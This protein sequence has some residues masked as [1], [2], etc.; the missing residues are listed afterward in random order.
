MRLRDCLFRSLLRRLPSCIDW[1]I[2]QAEQK[3]VLY[4][5]CHLSRGYLAVILLL[6]IL[7]ELMLW[8][9]VQN[10]P[11][12][13]SNVQFCR[14]WMGLLG[15]CI[16]VFTNFAFVRGASVERLRTILEPLREEA[17][18]NGS[19]VASVG[20]RIGRRYLWYIM[21]YLFFVLTSILVFFLEAVRQWGFSGLS[22]E[23]VL[24]LGPLLLTLGAF[25]AV[26]PFMLR[27]QGAGAR[28]LP[29]LGSVT[30]C[31]A[32][33]IASA[34]PL[35][36]VIVDPQLSRSD[37][38]KLLA[39]RSYVHGDWNGP[40]LLLSDGRVA[41]KADVHD[42]YQGIRIMGWALISGSVLF[43]CVGMMFAINSFH[44]TTNVLLYLQQMKR[45]PDF[46]S[47]RETIDPRHFMAPF[48]I[49]W[50]CVWFSL[51]CCL[52]VASA[53]VVRSAL[54]LVASVGCNSSQPRLN[55]IDLSV[56][57]SAMAFDIAP[58]RAWLVWGM[59]TV[60]GCYVLLF[61][62]IM[63]ASIGSFV[64]QEWAARQRLVRATKELEQ[65][66]VIVSLAE[67]L[68]RY[69]PSTQLPDIISI[70]G[71]RIFAHARL[72]GFLRRRAVIEVSSCCKEVLTSEE[73]YALL[74]HELAHHALGHSRRDMTLRFLG[75]LTLVG[76]G[77]VRILEDSFGYEL[78]ADKF[79]VETLGGDPG[80]MIRCLNK[81][82]IS[83]AM[84]NLSLITPTAGLP[85]KS[86]NLPRATTTPNRNVSRAWL[87]SVKAGAV[88]QFRQYC[89]IDNAAYWHPSTAQRIA[90]LKKLSTSR[91]GEQQSGTPCQESFIPPRNPG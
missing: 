53:G 80:A 70:A 34:V 78:Q 4:C 86:D 59:H 38:E 87:R 52:L 19:V 18:A 27:Y 12:P 45:G 91:A 89:G 56:L 57:L 77:F 22:R 33:L 17:L 84:E 36:W 25:C 31:I 54:N 47:I 3:T 51:A 1:R 73:V 71:D 49:I 69:A 23:S 6:G 37:A 72:V 15:F 58:D 13:F 66:H 75:R 85:I 43:G 2:W 41:Q 16:L 81:L 46:E 5:D 55:I 67:R 24:I 62:G 40:P 28:L 35:P 63:L 90:A 83:Q 88:M 44:C 60:W 32:V 21:G 39:T 76:D 26:I 64:M 10:I 7:T 79:A 82:Q 14:F 48:R 68:R 65:S 74:A 29:A 42:V 61:M 8:V 11:H 20:R 9:G 30:L 50:G